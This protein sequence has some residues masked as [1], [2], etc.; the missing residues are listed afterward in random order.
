[1]ATSLVGDGTPEAYFRE[2]VKA[3]VREDGRENSEFRK[4]VVEQ[5]VV[6]HASGSAQVALGRT[7]VLAAATL[8]IGSPRE[9]RPS[10]GVVSVTVDCAMA[11]AVAGT[12]WRQ[13]DKHGQD[14]ARH[15]EVSVDT[16][17][18]CC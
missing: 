9:G 17:T 11:F 13:Y 18:R 1:M 4:V 5:G 6:D 3:N 14:L 8:E 15:I 2:G 10:A 16:T 12:N 7:K